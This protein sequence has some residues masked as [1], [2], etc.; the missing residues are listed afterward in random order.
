MAEK[1]IEVNVK[2]RMAIAYGYGEITP[3]ELPD[4]QMEM[5]IATCNEYKTTGFD[6]GEVKPVYTLAPET[7]VIYVLPFNVMDKE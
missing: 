4:L 7:R 1:Y 6:F 2:A 3:A 5:E